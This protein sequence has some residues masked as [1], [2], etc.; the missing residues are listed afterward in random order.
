[1]EKEHQPVIR[2]ALIG[3]ECTSKSSLSEALAEHYQ[4]LWV[5][6]YAREYLINLGRKYTLEDIAAIAKGQLARESE[7]LKKA[8]RF[9]FA[10]TELIISKVWCEDVFHACPEW[11]TEHIS[12][13]RYDLYLLTYPDIP[14]V[15]DPLRENPHRRDFLYAWYER[16]LKAIG[17]DYSVIRGVGASRLANAIAAVEDL[18]K[19]KGQ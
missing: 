13:H 15:A 16:E 6:E 10:D 14:W 4:T 2:V 19:R 11:I 7:L 1:M 5:K 3:P 18:R 9:I 17:A 12:S 8:S